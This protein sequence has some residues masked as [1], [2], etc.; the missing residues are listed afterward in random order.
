MKLEQKGSIDGLLSGAG[1]YKETFKGTG[2][3]FLKCFGDF[4]HVELKEGEKIS[5]DT[6]HLLAHDE[7]VE[8]TIL[9]NEGDRFDSFAEGEIL[10]CEFTGPGKVWLQ[11]RNRSEFAK[12]IQTFLPKKRISRLPD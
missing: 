11:T 10:V 9:K 1:L 2:H 12:V 3:L 7:S 5:I 4:M 6:G 8:L